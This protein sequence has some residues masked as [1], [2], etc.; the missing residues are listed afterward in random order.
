[1]FEHIDHRGETATQIFSEP[2]SLAYQQDGTSASG[3]EK[4][5]GGKKQKKKGIPRTVRQKPSHYSFGFTPTLL[6]DCFFDCNGIG[7][8]PHSNQQLGAAGAALADSDKLASSPIYI[9]INA[10]TLNNNT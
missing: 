3:S 2:M 4:K 1:M 10:W 8:V 5:S 9:Y 6:R 7:G